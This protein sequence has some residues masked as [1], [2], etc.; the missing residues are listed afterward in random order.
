MKKLTALLLAM[1][2]TLSLV[3]CGSEVPMSSNGA[4]PD[5]EK[6]PA[7]TNSVC[8]VWVKTNPEFL[9]Y[10][11]ENGSIVELTSL[12]EDAKTAF[13]GVDVVN[14]DFETGLR[15]LLDTAYDAGYINGNELAI[16]WNISSSSAEFDEGVIL[17]GFSNVTE[18]FAKEKNLD[19]SVGMEDRKSDNEIGGEDAADIDEAV[20]AEEKAELN[21]SIEAGETINTE[22]PE[23]IDNGAPQ[24]DVAYE[25]PVLYRADFEIPDVFGTGYTNAINYYNDFP[26]G[27]DG[28]TAGNLGIGIYYKGFE[29]VI[30]AEE[31][32]VFK[33]HRGIGLGSKV[34]EVYEAYGKGWIEPPH[35]GLLGLNDNE[36][37]VEYF[38]FYP[39]R[40]ASGAAVDI[41]FY[42][43][44]NDTVMGIDIG[45]I[46]EKFVTEELE[47]RLFEIADE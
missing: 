25:T 3:A 29:S 30:S 47:K 16:Q 17:E 26:D 9:L 20:D 36:H 5:G 37:T 42:I 32:L 34:E 14:A 10:L 44:Q 28:G 33:T 18:A 12:N 11:D 45:G 43:D 46:Y 24:E 23:N 13:E 2:M 8:S 4:S 7:P 40:I 41:R 27:N 35:E 31:A 1:M 6:N 38:V 15:I 22:V 39:G 19:Y 21:T